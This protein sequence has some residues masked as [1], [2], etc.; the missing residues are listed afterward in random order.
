MPQD[1]AKAKVNLISSA[2]KGPLYLFALISLVLEAGLITAVSLLKENVIAQTILVVGIIVS[3]ILIIYLVGTKV[4][5]KEIR[6]QEKYPTHGELLGKTAVDG[7]YYGGPTEI[8][9]GTWQVEW[10]EWDE[11]HQ[12]VPYKVT[13]DGKEIDYPPDEANVRVRGPQISVQ[14]TDKTTRYVYYLE[15]R[16]SN[17]SVVTLLYWSQ[18]RV[19]ESALVGVMLL[20]LFNRYDETKLEGTYTGYDRNEQIK[21]GECVWTKIGRSGGSQ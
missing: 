13:V 3:L 2:G 1:D 19:K 4:L 9:Y 7:F 15:G 10:F 21:T 17:K 18:P 6:V 8:L 20:K 11:N 5:G 14:S 12:R 16:M